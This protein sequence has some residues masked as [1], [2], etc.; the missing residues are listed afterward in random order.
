[1]TLKQRLGTST[2]WMS[3]AAS[4]NSLVSF[5]IFIVLS[6]I[7]APEQIGLVAFALIVVE[8]GKI[9]V[10]AGFAQ[11]IVQHPHFDQRYASTCFFSNFFFALVI[12]L[13]VIFIGVPLV[14]HY[15]QEAAGKVLTVLSAIFLIEGVKAVHEGKLKRE[16]AFQVIAMRTVLAG[17]M[18]GL[19]GIYLALQGYGVWA[20]VWQQLTSQFVTSVFTIFYGK[21][22]PSLIFSWADFKQLIRFSTP[23]MLAQL[24]GNISTSVFELWI[25]IILGPAALG[26]YRVGGRA[27]Y[28]LQDVVLK[29]FEHTAL[30][31][32]SRLDNTQQQAQG[33]LRMLRMSAYLTLPI[34]FGAAAI[35]PHFIALAFGE[36]W[37]ASGN[38]MSILAIAIAPL[39]IGYHTNAALTA[40]GNSRFVM[41]QACA[42]LILSLLLGAISIP[43]GLTATAYA[44]AARNYLMTALQ[45]LLFKK[46]FSVN[47]FALCKSFASSGTASLMMFFS[48]WQTNQW[49]NTRV[50]EAI[51][52]VLLCAIGGFIYLALMTTLFRTETKHFFKESLDLAPATLKPFIERIQYLIRLT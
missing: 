19:V 49:L 46:V 22:A 38:I 44:F 52:I 47:G 21:W 33:T 23:L 1:M 5:V 20:L 32:L 42:T 43:F 18:S 41:F 25:G 51:N 15:Y 4:G 3:L 27:I 29:P 40:S 7:L 13:C 39:V 45:L 50:P 17:L 36:K 2:L 37:Q 14:V 12:T 11:A 10:N 48:V 8:M 30:S 34:F 28:I 6:R 16:F 31:A 35:A 26:F 9:L 24:I